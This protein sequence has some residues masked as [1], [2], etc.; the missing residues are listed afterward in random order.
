MSDFT[1]F[2]SISS[3]LFI[4][5]FCFQT[6][7][8][9]CSGHK[10]KQNG[11]RTL[12]FVEFFTGFMLLSDALA[13]FYR[14]NTTA[15]GF[16]M[17]R[18]SNF[19]VFVCNA[20]V[21]FFLCFYVCEFIKQSRLNFSILLA[22]RDSMKK[23]IPVHLFIVLCLCAVN[24]CLIVVSQFTDFFYY[25]D[26]KNLYHRSTFY[27]LSVVLGILPE[28]IVF[29]MLL[30]NRKKL[31]LNVF[32]SLL[33]YFSLPLLSVALIL[34]SYGFP[35]MNVS[36]GLGALHLFYSSM[37]LLEL[38]FCSENRSALIAGPVYKTEAVSTE[39]KKRVVRSHFWQALSLCLGGIIFVLVI[40]SIKGVSL[41]EK[42]LTIEKPYTEN[43]EEKS[44][45]VTFSRNA[46][47]QWVDGDDI[48]RTGAQYDGVIFNNMKST[49][50]T[51]WKFS[52]SVPDNSSVDPG[53]WNGTFSLSGG[54]LNVNKPHEG[55]K[56]NIHG[57]DFY[58]ITPLKTLGFGC[59]MYTP[60]D[61]QPL[62]QEIVFTYSCVLKPLTNTFFDIFLALLFVVFII[63]T[64]VM[65]FEGKLIR[66]EEE[67]RKL[68]STVKE[69]TREL[70]A[71]KNRSEHLLLNILPKE[72]AKELSAHPESTIAKEYPNVTVLFTDIVGFT[73]ISGEMTA[74]EVV[75]M[76]NKMF[77]MF[78]E[79][80]QR[81]GI[82]KIKTIGDAY[83]AAAGLTLEHFND[84]AFR[85]IR[86]AKGLLSDVRAF[87]E[88]SNIKLQIRLG[89]NSGPLVAG[90]IG[91][92]KFI[93][94]IWGDTVNVA[95]R[96]EST[97][98]PMRI[99]VTEMTKVQTMSRYE[100]SKNTEIDVKGKGMMKTYF[101]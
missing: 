72:I 20:S 85:M 81:E 93:Y 73:K 78:D 19:F 97:G 26:D 45:C 22:P 83:M 94:D 42:K 39:S 49:I 75:T 33:L 86:F 9:L 65:L 55:D 79:R 10:L 100:Y 28:I 90:V 7:I 56:E 4:S 24:F 51:D 5:F 95:S 53:P 12:V 17:V 101:L 6:G 1:R 58:R 68:E 67:N 3:L 87:N 23:G 82:E 44:V 14:G 96:M 46:E 50:I 27:P 11:R 29:T 59:I 76:L 13:Y 54:R 61:Y 99:H 62:A 25:F 36:F 92:T 52:I 43:D 57:E 69:R 98:L 34:V 8:F 84:G 15:V 74:E 40:V 63:S 38:E 80:A 18:L 21:S 2:I 64:T 16:Y 66:V 37:K 70:E 77:S 60:H 91:K 41:P 48:G 89:I 71:E 47:K 88:T 32:V 30:Q 35:W 31:A